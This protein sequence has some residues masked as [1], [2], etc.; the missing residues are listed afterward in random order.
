MAPKLTA[1]GV[2]I[3]LSFRK[4]VF[5]VCYFVLLLIL[6]KY[7]PFGPASIWAGVNGGPMRFP[8]K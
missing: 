5:V 6:Q 2:T 3:E 8:K 7:L 1:F 4:G